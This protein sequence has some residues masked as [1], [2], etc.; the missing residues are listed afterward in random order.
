MDQNKEIEL[1][2][3][4]TDAGPTDWHALPPKTPS[5]HRL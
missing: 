3:K 4:L 5:E 1:A 2:S